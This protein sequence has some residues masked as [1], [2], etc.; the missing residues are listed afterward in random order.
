MN[1]TPSLSSV[2]M[3]VEQ[4]QARIDE[5]AFSVWLGLRVTVVRPQ[6][7]GFQ[8]PWREEFIG[9]KRLAQVH[10]GVIAA[11]VD[12]SG[13]YTLM[14]HTGQTLSTVDLRVDFH[15]GAS[16]GTMQIEGCVVHLGR[17]LACVDVRILDA[18]AALISSGRATYY[19][20]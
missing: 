12:A 4:L 20:P 13:G 5:N 19:T 15:R 1:D 17:K 6:S 2:T 3:N 16:V 11:L 14:A 7:V 18:G 10:G 8:I 9:T